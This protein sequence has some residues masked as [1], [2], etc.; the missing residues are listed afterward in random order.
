MRQ[1]HFLI[2]KVR[3]L[4]GRIKEEWDTTACVPPLH[5]EKQ[6]EGPNPYQSQ[7][8][9]F[10]KAYQQEFWL[11]HWKWRFCLSDWQHSTRNIREIKSEMES[12]AWVLR[13]FIIVELKME[14]I[15]LKIKMTT[16]KM[17]VQSLLKTSMIDRIMINV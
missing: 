11:L 1:K 3:K 8:I 12:W 13:K 6:Q 9:T 15:Y 10:L 5:R 4:Y 2:M 17:I 14:N 16:K 7:Q